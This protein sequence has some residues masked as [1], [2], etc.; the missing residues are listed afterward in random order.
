MDNNEINETTNA[1][2]TTV[3][4]KNK[5]KNEI[6]EWIITIAIF[7]GFFMFIRIVIGQP[8][9][10]N[11]ESM[12]PTLVH[13]DTIF[14]EKLS[15]IFGSPDRGD[16]IVF[17]Y[18]ADPSKDYIKR[19]IGVPGDVI[20]IVENDFYVNDEL[21]DDDFKLQNIPLGDTQFPVTVG[22]NEYF[23]LGDNRAVSHDSRHSEVGLI[24]EEDIVGRA[25]FVFY[26]LNRIKLVR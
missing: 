24:K 1:T 5:N 22:D 20:D 25:F 16:I 11:G 7:I 23:V 19:V 4:N 10:T 9:V 13:G 6:K 12:A 8:V 17:P 3:D 2:E 26:P 18:P 14:V 15:Y 21:L